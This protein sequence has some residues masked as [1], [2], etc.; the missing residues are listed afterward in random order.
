VSHDVPKPRERSGA[1]A[2]VKSS[3]TGSARSLSNRKHVRKLQSVYS[4]RERLGRIVCRGKL[5]FEVYDADDH[6][7]GIFPTVKAAAD[8]L[9][10]RRVAS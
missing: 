1:S 8:A 3:T 10:D 4:G 5:G 2:G 6:S 9:S 7:L